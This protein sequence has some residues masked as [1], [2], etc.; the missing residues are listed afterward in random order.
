V[1]QASFPEIPMDWMLRRPGVMV[2]CVVAWLGGSHCLAGAKFIDKLA[3]GTPQTIVVYGTSL[4]AGGGEPQQRWVTQ[5]QTILKDFKTS[6]PAS[7]PATI[8]NSGQ[9]GK[10]SNTALKLLKTAVIEKKPDVVFLEFATNDA[11]QAYK[12]GDVDFEPKI[13]PERSQ[14]NLNAMIDAIRAANPQVEI[15]VQTMNPAWDAPNGRGSA[16][17]RPQLGAYFEGY[18]QVAAQRGVTLID[19]EPAWIQLVQDN[20]KAFHTYVADGIHPNDAGYAAVVRP[21]LQRVLLKSP[22]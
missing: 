16:S 13:T 20:P 3:A 5:L 21:L 4:T 9:S 18:R 15:F 14:A 6:H 19:Y 10:A 17:K 7:A 22:E 11:F 8:I 1:I 2:A 12:P